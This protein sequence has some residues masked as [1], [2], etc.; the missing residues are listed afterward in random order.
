MGNADSYDTP[1]R[2]DPVDGES[3]RILEG[4]SAN[5]AEG[6][7]LASALARRADTLE[8]ARR[9]RFEADAAAALREFNDTAGD[10]VRALEKIGRGYDAITIRDLRISP[11]ARPRSR[12]AQVPMIALHCIAGS[13]AALLAMSEKGIVSHSTGAM[14]GL[15]AVV[16]EIVAPGIMGASKGREH[17][18]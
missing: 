11:P 10:L 13:G 7:S 17:G 9:R 15:L 1:T 12:W 14:G 5:W 3:R 18:G 8:G 2:G 6:G 4:L 16:A